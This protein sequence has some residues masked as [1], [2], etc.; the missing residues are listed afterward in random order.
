[1]VTQIYSPNTIGR[2]RLE[3]ERFKGQ[4]WLYSE[5]EANL[6]CVRVCPPKNKTENKTRMLSWEI[7]VS[8]PKGPIT[9]SKNHHTL[10]I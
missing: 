9:N 6:G 2:W 3:D 7:Y 4:P 5:S 1:M 10:F 8:S